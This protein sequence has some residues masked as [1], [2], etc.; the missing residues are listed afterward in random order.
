MRSAD[1]WGRL[2]PIWLLLLQAGADECVRP[3][4]ILVRDCDWFGTFLLRFRQGCGDVVEC[5]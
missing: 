5:G 2:S 3:Y 1:S 4:V